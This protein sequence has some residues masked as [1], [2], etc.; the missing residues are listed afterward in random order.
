MAMPCEHFIRG[1][2]INCLCQILGK[3]SEVRK[4]KLSKKERKK[5]ITRISEASG[6]AQY[7]LDAKMTDEQVIEAANNLK[8]FLLIRA[9]NNYNRYCQA[10]KTAEANAK[11]KQFIDPKN[12]EIY[13]AGQWLV[14]ALSKVGSNRKQSLLEK[15][16]VHKDDYN[17]AITDLKDTI[18]G[19]KQGIQQQTSEASTKLHDLENTVDSLRKQLVLL[20]DYIT[21]NYG[22][23]DWHKIAKH[24]Q[25][26]I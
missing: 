7:A 2:L 14:N 5:L 16:L 11:L 6:V 21:N 26:N 4:M 13:Q 8:L 19:Q 10:Q 25:K 3:A 24:I 15:D 22:L 9:A 1:H 18:D 23:N 17:Q 20:K 12:S